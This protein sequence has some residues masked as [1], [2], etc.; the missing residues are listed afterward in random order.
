MM[1]AIVEGVTEAVKGL[2]ELERKM[3]N[4]IIRKG[5]RAGG[6]VWRDAARG[7]A[8]TRSGKT[9]RAIKVR[10]GK[11]T[12]DSISVS[13]GISDKDYSGEAFYAA[14][15]L[16][17]H[18]VGRRSLGDARKLVPANNFLE[19]AYNQSGQA[20]GDKAIEVMKEELENQGTK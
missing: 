9:R 16:Y 11:R 20:A 10:A 19:R 14:F 1:K 17:G 13:V 8:P 15:V 12:K 4:K 18:R 2:D 5:L 7:E 3:Q 6:K